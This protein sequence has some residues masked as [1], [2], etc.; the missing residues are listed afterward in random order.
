MNKELNEMEE[1]TKEQFEAY[2]DVQMS[3]VTNMFNVKLVGELSGL[4][5]EQI[6][7]IMTHYGEL[8]DK[9]DE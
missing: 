6:M 4:E 1:I 8:K 2:V 9:Y 7:T 5:K 3:G